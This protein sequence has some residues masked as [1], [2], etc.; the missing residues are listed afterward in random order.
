[1]CNPNSARLPYPIPAPVRGNDGGR[2]KNASPLPEGNAV[3]CGQREALFLNPASPL[4]RKCTQK[5][6]EQGMELGYRAN[7]L[8]NQANSNKINRYR[9]LPPPSG[10]SSYAFFRGYSRYVHCFSRKHDFAWPPLL[11]IVE[12]T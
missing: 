12:E 3:R 11:V 10:L 2:A 6:I 5:I 1:M 4:S 8:I 9:H 7:S